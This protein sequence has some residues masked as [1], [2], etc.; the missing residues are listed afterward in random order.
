MIRE[1]NAPSESIESVARK[2]S[3]IAERCINRFVA[4]MDFDL[5]DA[6]AQRRLYGD[7]LR[8]PVFTQRKVE[9]DALDM[10]QKSRDYSAELMGQWGEAFRATVARN[11]VTT[12]AGVD[13]A[14]QNAKLGEILK[15]LTA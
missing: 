7:D 13:D 3:L 5:I 4:Q 12:T 2:I 14:V 10:P 8:E 9:F 6:D 15:A 11:A 1:S